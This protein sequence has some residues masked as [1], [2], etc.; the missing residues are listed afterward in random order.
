[1]KVKFSTEELKS[2][3][4]QLAAVV[5]KKAAQPVYGF[6]RVVTG[7]AQALETKRPV[8]I[9]GLDIDASLTVRLVNAEAD[10][11]FD[12]LVPFGK[13][14]EILS[15]VTV[16]ECTIEAADETKA[17]FKAGKYRAE[18]RP[19]PLVNWPTIPERPDV[20]VATIGLAGFK[21]QLANVEF[22]VPASDGK[23]IVAVAKIESTVD[24]PAVGDKPAVPGFL[25]AVATD[26]FRLAIASVVSSIG[27]F[28]LI[29]PKPALELVK[30][31]DGGE[32]L[33]ILEAEAG[34]QFETD[35]ETLTVSRSHGTFP[36]Y[37]RVFPATVNATITVDKSVLL[38]AI[39]RV[40][41]LGDLE[42]P[43][44][45]F[46]GAENGT[47]IELQT[48]SP[49]AGGE[50]VFSNAASD[51][52]EAKIV[53]PAIE[54]AL[55][56][57]YLAPFLEKAY[58]SKTGEITIRVKDGKSVVDFY[59]NAGQYRFLQAPSN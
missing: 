9:T 39:K 19:H 42:K 59:A 40:T 4:G 8:Y 53:G 16:A 38:A 43:I 48:S 41:P 3:L 17:T 23:H 55:N 32:K 31:L 29:I 28:E 2:R 25:R 34:F 22:A 58:G 5:A 11:D 37:E 50:G 49:D 24:A 51:E 44:I 27:V 18:L 13:L 30:K 45:S 12:V 7:E 54:F 57:K 14:L 21:D 35:L 33:T 20:S 52:V 10:G 46:K 56:A 26:G 6:V 1:M 47:A 15:S 36:Q